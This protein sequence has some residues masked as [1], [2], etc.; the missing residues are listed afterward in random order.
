[1][2]VLTAGG[3]LTN[4]DAYV[5]TWWSAARATLPSVAL[6]SVPQAL[7]LKTTRAP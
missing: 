5:T 2:D 7:W 3:I 1:M 4:R 6:P